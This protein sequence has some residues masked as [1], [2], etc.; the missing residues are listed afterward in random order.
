[1]KIKNCMTISDS[2]NIISSHDMESPKQH[3]PKNI[4]TG[5]SER[6]CRWIAKEAF[7]FMHAVP[8]NV[9]CNTRVTPPAYIFGR[10]L[11]NDIRDIQ[12]RVARRCGS[13]N[14]RR[15]CWGYEGSSDNDVEC[16]CGYEGPSDRHVAVEDTRGHPTCQ[17]RGV[18]LRI[19]EDTRQKKRN[20]VIPDA[21]NM[22]VFR[23]SAMGTWLQ[24]KKIISLYIRLYFG[25]NDNRL[26]P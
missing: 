21:T 8:W 25:R 19:C 5:V 16:R 22:P 15:R 4:I 14:I 11:R 24:R 13:G 3:G 7:I 6:S 17:P 20:H 23:V 1:M 18:P 12:Q 26:I 2:A 10:D 9:R